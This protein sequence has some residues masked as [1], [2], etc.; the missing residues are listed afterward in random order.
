MKMLDG[1]VLPG[2]AITVAADM[3][4]GEKTFARSARSSSS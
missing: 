4:K 2:E 3:K 1:E